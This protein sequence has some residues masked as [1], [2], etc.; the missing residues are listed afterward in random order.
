MPHDTHNITVCFLLGH[1]NWVLRLAHRHTRKD[2]SIFHLPLS[3][4]CLYIRSINIV[5][6][7]ILLFLFLFMLRLFVVSSASN[8]SA[9][10]IN[11][12][13]SIHKCIQN[14]FAWI[15][16]NYGAM[17]FVFVVL[18]YVSVSINFYLGLATHGNLADYNHAF[19]TLLLPPLSLFLL[20]VFPLF[21]VT[22]PFVDVAIA[23]LAVS[24]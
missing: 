23:L 13:Y 18:F 16:L 22:E 8:A 2:L 12:K 24:Y 14:N 5:L 1:K 3:F 10:Y 19:L 21:F 9:F 11:N 15:L 7:F 6:F 20:F 4:L 17:V